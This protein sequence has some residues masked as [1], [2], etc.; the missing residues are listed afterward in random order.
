MNRLY[1]PEE[2]EIMRTP[3]HSGMP[4]S[5]G[6]ERMSDMHLKGVRLNTNICRYHQR[7]LGRQISGWGPQVGDAGIPFMPCTVHCDGS[8]GCPTSGLRLYKAIPHNS[9]AGSF[10]Q[11]DSERRAVDVFLQAAGLF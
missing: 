9:V 8:T 10:L 3:I 4:D 7:A 5:G 11:H 2:F 6:L 1:C